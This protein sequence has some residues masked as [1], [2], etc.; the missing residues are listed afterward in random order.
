MPRL[1][2][3]S[4]DL[5]EVTVAADQSGKGH[6]VIYKLSEVH[7][8]TEGKF[9]L[10]GTHLRQLPIFPGMDVPADSAK[11]QVKGVNVMTVRKTV[12]RYGYLESSRRKPLLLKNKM[13]ARCLTMSEPPE[14]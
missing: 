10:R 4:N 13:A 9:F 8:S 2:D 3:I 6:K 11:G 1:K 12:N 5:R 7:R 14:A